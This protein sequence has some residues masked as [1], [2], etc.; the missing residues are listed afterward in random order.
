M[1]IKISHTEKFPVTYVGSPL[2]SWWSLT[3]Y[4]LSEL[5][6]VTCFQRKDYGKRGKVTSQWR[7]LANIT[8]TRWSKLLLS[9]ISRGNCMHSQYDGTKMG[10]HLHGLP[11]PK[12]TILAKPWENKSDISNFE[13]I[14]QNTWPDQYSFDGKAME[15]KRSLRNCHSFEENKETWQHNV[16]CYP[17]ENPGTEKEH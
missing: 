13:G 7:N 17:E 6:L 10:F 16:M 9:V 5:C 1:K 4:P 15:N 14:L 2:S 12:P 11:H 8:S 3:P